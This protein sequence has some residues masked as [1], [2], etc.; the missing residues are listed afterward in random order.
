M[1]DI[2][3]IEEAAKKLVGHYGWI[4]VVGFLTFFFKDL[5]NSTVQG[6]LIML[7]NDMNNDDILYIS[8]RKARVVR[9]GFRKTIF[10]MEDRHTKMIVPNDKLQNL[11]IEKSLPTNGIL[12]KGID[13]NLT[14]EVFDGKKMVTKK[15]SL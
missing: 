8:G 3:I 6:L 2:K 10:Y 5:I 13:V 15:D 14:K 11:T 9:V 1:D 4:F 12:G 7:G